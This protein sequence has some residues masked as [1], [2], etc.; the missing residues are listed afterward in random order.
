MAQLTN[1]VYPNLFLRIIN[2]S[3]TKVIP[4]AASRGTYCASPDR[5]DREA[6]RATISSTVGYLSFRSTG[7]S[8]FPQIYGAYK[9][10]I[11]ANP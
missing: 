11:Y 2:H 7:R 8:Y 5:S 6:A 1:I 10:R 4:L 9:L 3:R